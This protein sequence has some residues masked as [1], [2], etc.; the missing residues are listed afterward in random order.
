MHF[1]AMQSIIMMLCLI[2]VTGFPYGQ[3]GNKSNHYSDIQ[4]YETHIFNHSQQRMKTIFKYIIHWIDY[5]YYRCV[6]YYT[7]KGHENDYI[8]STFP[9]FYSYMAIMQVID[10]TCNLNIVPIIYENR[11]PLT[12]VTGIILMLFFNE[13]RYKKAEAL[14]G[15]ESH[16]MKVIMGILVVLT[17]AIPVIAFL[18]VLSK[19][20]IFK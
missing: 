14:F 20:Q 13:K 2:D 9:F 12:I 15:N 1:V 16:S 6:H 3:S 18:I 8:Q 11:L 7:R 17:F 10:Y 19:R 5:C 4:S